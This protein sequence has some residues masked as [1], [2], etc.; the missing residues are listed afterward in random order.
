MRIQVIRLR[1]CGRSGSSA[2][3]REYLAH[4]F[5][6][7]ARRH[8]E[9]QFKVE[10]RP[11]GHPVAVGVYAN[12]YE[13]VLDVKNLDAQEVAERVAYLRGMLGRPP[14]TPSQLSFGVISRHPSIQGMTRVAHWNVHTAER[15]FRLAMEHARKRYGVPSFGELVQELGMVQATRLYRDVEAL[16]RQRESRQRVRKNRWAR[17][18]AEREAAMTRGE[19]REDQLAAS[20]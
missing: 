19:E 18:D 16:A 3:M 8:P 1:Y 15:H 20:R 12:G 9:V 17:M 5:V 2:G 14:R 7:Y 11:Q 13:R 10:L 4:R 6:E